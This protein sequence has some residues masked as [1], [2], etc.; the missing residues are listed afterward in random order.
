MQDDGTIEQLSAYLDGELTD[1]EVA[2]LEHRLARDPGLQSELDGLRAAMDLMRTH[3]P[4]QAPAALYGDILRA[5]EDEPMPG[6]FWAWL[7]RPF[8]MPLPAV[9]LAAVGL[10]VVGVAVT[11][12]VAVNATGALRPAVSDLE[13]AGISKGDD[14][15]AGKDD[16]VA[17]A[18]PK[19]RAQAEGSAARP[20]SRDKV[21][22]AVNTDGVAALSAGDAEGEEA[23]GMAYETKKELGGLEP[24]ESQVEPAATLDVGGSG[25]T[26]G[27]G[28][29][30][31]VDNASVPGKMYSGHSLTSIA[32]RPEDLERVAALYQ[33]HA[34]VSKS[35]ASVAERIAGM[36]SGTRDFELTLPDEKARQAFE[37]DLNRLFS[38]RVSNGVSRDD[39]FTM[40]HARMTLRLTVS[41][42]APATGG[43]AEPIQMQ[44]LR[45]AKDEWDE[46][47]PT[48]TMDVDA[49]E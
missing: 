41:S 22:D 9:A 42:Y 7:R 38:G 46:S 3:G 35:S 23:Q 17:Q 13:Y 21:K 47:A 16:P 14:K 2:E 15:K 1:N 26:A 45:K 49:K 30:R 44:T 34:G 12:A 32:L 29:E 20:A 24:S 25:G 28:V 4:V 27:D 40:D 33:K 11:G 31:G 19:D 8:G 43:E 37:L 5:V 6:G 39:A 36:E 48:E 10:L 18:S